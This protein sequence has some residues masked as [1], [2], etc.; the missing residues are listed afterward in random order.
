MGDE[1]IAST[2]PVRGSMATTAPRWPTSACSADRL[3]ARVE[4]S[5]T[6][7]PALLL[8]VQALQQRLGAEAARQVAV[9]GGLDAGLALRRSV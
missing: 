6:F 1:A 3:H 2:W 5:C 7:A 9:V 4:V 8:Q